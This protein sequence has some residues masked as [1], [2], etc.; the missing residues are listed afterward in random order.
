MANGPRVLITGATGYVGGRLLAALE[1]DGRRRLRCMAREPDALRGRVAATT[2]VV[3]GDCLEPDSLTAALQDVDAAFYLVHSMGAGDGFAQRD[4]QAAQ[5]FAQAARAAGVGRIVYLGGLGAS[6]EGLSPHLRSRQETGARLGSTGVPV[7][8]L[9]ASVIVGSGSLSFEL[10][11]ALVERLPIMICPRW[12]AVPTQP[13]AIEDVLEY[14][15]ATLDLP[16]G[17]PGVFEIGG[18]DVVS[19]GDLMRELARQRGLRRLLIP[20]PVLTPHLSSLWLGLV[21]PLYARVGRQ[22]IDSLRNPTVVRSDRALRTFAVRPRPLKEAIARALQQE[23][24]AGPATRWF[25]ARSSA[26]LPPRS[27]GDAPHRRRVIDSRT[28]V[29]AAPPDRAFAPIARIGGAQGWYWGNALWRLRGFLDLLAGGVGMRRGR[30][31]PHRLSVGDAVD[32]WRVEAL[33]PD[34]LLRLAAEMRLPG[35]AWLEFEVAPLPDGRTTIRETAFFEPS[36]P[37]GWAYWIAL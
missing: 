35:R 6:G 7:I 21:T 15:L 26:A 17:E 32:W 5:N 34:R 28:R 2:E 27:R 37:A 4:A 16:P 14:L 10:V 18:P 36:G 12:V 23:G 1:A 8:E 24:A 31:D 33:V 20:I 3:R 9:R 11:R 22:L 13:I 30:P 29:V 19:Y 25:D